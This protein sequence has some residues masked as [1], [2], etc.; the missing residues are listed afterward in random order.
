MR[1]CVSSVNL[2]DRCRWRSLGSTSKLSHIS[3]W[4][5]SGT[6]HTVDEP[7]WTS[8]SLFPWRNL[9]IFILVFMEKHWETQSTAPFFSL[10]QA[11]GWANETAHCSH[12]C[13]AGNSFLSVYL[14]CFLELIDARKYG[15]DAVYLLQRKI[16]FPFSPW[17]VLLSMSRVLCQF[18]GIIDVV[19]QQ[20]INHAS[21]VQFSGGAT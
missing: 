16:T 1:S 3:A 20:A 11:L 2:C 8:W 15:Q 21:N 7:T 5:Q 17:S 12:Q 13:C 6:G 4:S 10:C 9:F 18:S 19:Q 14:F